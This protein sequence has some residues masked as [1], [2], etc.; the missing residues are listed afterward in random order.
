[1]KNRFLAVTISFIVISSCASKTTETQSKIEK[2]NLTEVKQPKENI[3]KDISV[4]EY[5]NMISDKSIILDVRTPEEFVKGHL[6]GA[7]NINYFD[8]NFIEQVSSLDK[9]KAL[10]I[11]CAAGG[12]SAKAM[13]SLK[14]KGFSKLY[15]MLGGY[16][17]W[18]GAGHSVVK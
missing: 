5:K 13:N 14:D 11:H 16:N 10:L 7:I 3:A 15:N 12:R 4:E 18:V 6:D 17:A 1:M 2:K 8:E 9:S